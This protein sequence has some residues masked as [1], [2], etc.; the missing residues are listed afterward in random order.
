MSRKR[1]Q[2]CARQRPN[3]ESP[4]PHAAPLFRGPLD[5]AVPVRICNERS[6]FSLPGQAQIVENAPCRDGRPRNPASNAGARR[7]SLDTQIVRGAA[8]PTPRSTPQPFPASN[9]AI[10]IGRASWRE[11]VG[12]YVLISVGRVTLK[13]KTKRQT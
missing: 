1:E 9:R 5:A 10:P 4:E 11:R 2:R 13:K 6:V 12:P 7:W 8:W 3:R